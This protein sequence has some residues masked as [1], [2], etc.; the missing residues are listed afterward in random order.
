MGDPWVILLLV[1]FNVRGVLI[2]IVLIL[3]DGWGVA[4]SLFV[5]AIV[6]AS[7]TVNTDEWGWGV[8]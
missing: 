3:P 4:V 7:S 2:A 1:G 5:V 6:L 8:A